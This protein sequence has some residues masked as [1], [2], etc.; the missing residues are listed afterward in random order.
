MAQSDTP[1]RS[2]LE[3]L[4]LALD[5]GTFLD[6]RRMLN[7]LP[8]ADAAHLLESSPPNIRH[9]LW[10]M[11]DPENEGEVLN[12]LGD[13]LRLEILEDLEAPQVAAMME[14]LEDDDVADI[15]QQL[16]DRITFEVLNSM[17]HQDRSRIER[18]LLYPEDTAG[19]LMNTCLLYT[20]PSPRD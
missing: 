6:V 14:G 9:V 1:S 13:D 11:I 10:T 20:S 8:P 3:K 16:P 15:L 19:G 12:E 17:D 2:T 18:V 4:N 5:S 7:G